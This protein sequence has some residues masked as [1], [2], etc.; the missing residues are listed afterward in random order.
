MNGG[1]QATTLPMLS[2]VILLIPIRS[3][4]H[5]ADPESRVTAG[6]EAQHSAADGQMQHGVKKSSTSGLRTELSMVKP[7]SGRMG[8]SG[9]HWRHPNSGLQQDASRDASLQRMRL[10]HIPRPQG[11]EHYGAHG[12]P[13]DVLTLPDAAPC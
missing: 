5:L 13:L 9:S 2:S 3:P 6:P 12:N 1:L 7:F 10:N 11:A 8:V 4:R